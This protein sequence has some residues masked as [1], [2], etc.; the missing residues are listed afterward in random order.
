[1]F[2]PVQNYDRKWDQNQQQ[3]KLFSFNSYDSITPFDA[4][5]FFFP[6]CELL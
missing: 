4:T 2:K 1:M 3:Y 6:G 5:C